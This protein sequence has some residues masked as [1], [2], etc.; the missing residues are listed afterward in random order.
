MPRPAVLISASVLFAACACS[1][2]SSSPQTAGSVA[3]AAAPGTVEI[4]VTEDGFVPA[5]AVVK[6]GGPVTLVVTRKTDK[7]CA[8][9]IV[10]K[11]YGINQP[12]P[13]G[14]PVKV[15]LTPRERGTIGYACAMD[16][17]KGTLTVE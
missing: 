4:A 7:T 5:N 15:T 1:E 10:I 2:Q 11:D 16:M 12:L 17:I 13:L 6:Q 8:T 9:E 14:Q 3:S